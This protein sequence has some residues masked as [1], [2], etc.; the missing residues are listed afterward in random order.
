MHCNGGKGRA[1]TV[2]VAWLMYH[3]QIPAKVALKLVKAKRK[4]THLTKLGG[5]LPVWKL[6]MKWEKKLLSNA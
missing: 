4:I 1:A 3:D 6:L 5:I 2:A